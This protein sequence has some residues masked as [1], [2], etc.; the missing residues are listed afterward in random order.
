MSR[1]KSGQ[2]R[3]T[4]QAGAIA[5]AT[6]LGHELGRFYA[7]EGKSNRRAT[8]LVRGRMIE[9]AMPAVFRAEC[10]RCGAAAIVDQHEWKNDGKGF[11]GKATKEAC[12]GPDTPT[13]AGE[14]AARAAMVGR[15][16]RG[17]LLGLALLAGVAHAAPLGRYTAP[18]G[19]IYFGSNPP[20]GAVLGASYAGRE[21]DAEAVDN[22]IHNFAERAVGGLAR[23]ARLVNE[24]L[25]G[26]PTNCPTCGR[27][28]I[29]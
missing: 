28:S 10:R 11:G 17:T 21:R 13:S 26:H 3:A 5:A 25:R 1:A 24:E 8:V 2:G 27:E 22:P 19:S 16:F 6:V 14:K 29:R 18:D 12:A 7:D 9:G 15:L 20:A 23:G 4:L